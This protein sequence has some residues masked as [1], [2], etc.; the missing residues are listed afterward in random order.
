MERDFRGGCLTFICKCFLL[1]VLLQQPA[2]ANTSSE[3][4]TEAFEKQWN[5]SDSLPEQIELRVTREH[6]LIPLGDNLNIFRQDATFDQTISLKDALIMCLENN[7]PIQIAASQTETERWRMKAAL[8][9]F[10]PDINNGYSD[11]WQKGQLSINGRLSLDLNNPYIYSFSSIRY[12]G[13]RGGSVLYGALQQRNLLRAAKA[14]Q[15]GTINDA[16]LEVSKRYNELLL[17]EALLQIQIKAVQT[18]ELQLEHNRELKANGAITKLE[19]LQAKAQLARDKQEQINGEFELRK[20]SI[21]LTNS[22]NLRTGVNLTVRDRTITKRRLIKPNTTIVELIDIGLSNRPELKKLEQERLAAHKA[23]HVALAP[24]LP[25]FSIMGSVI[26]SGATASKSYETSSPS[27]A[28]VAVSGQGTTQNV[29]GNTAGALPSVVNVYPLAS[30]GAQTVYPAGVVAVPAQNT[31][32]RINSDFNVG[33]NLEWNLPGLGLPD[34]AGV[35]ASKT[36]ART[37]MLRL[38]E[39]VLDVINEIRVSYLRSCSA[40]RRIEQASDEV[41]AAE[42]EL[43]VAQERIDNGLGTNLDVITAQ[44]DATQ[45]LVKKAQAIIEFNNAQIQLLHDTG[46]ISVDTICSGR[47]YGKGGP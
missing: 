31:S 44:R 37:A 10:L 18:S 7:Q 47:L 2:I 3:Q 41:E 33:W 27:Y 29:L 1:M 38:N 28:A 12:Y 42:E 23:I 39:R 17:R 4:R 6:E 26:G 16:Y 40:E 36:L 22:L 11:T 13:F 24:L 45:A 32:T 34:A 5:K 21:D 46:V 14:N 19:L 43:R 25:R 20:A 9:R 35:V 15:I 30:T 8:A